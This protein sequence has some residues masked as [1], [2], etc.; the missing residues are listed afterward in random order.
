MIA[1]MYVRSA[2]LVVALAFVGS[3]QAGSPSPCKLATIADVKA[4]FGGTVGP[5]KVDN[6]AG[7]PACRFAVKKSNLGVDGTAVV[8][9]TPGQSAATFKIAKKEVPGAVAVAGVGNAAFYDPHT[10]SIEMLKG[11]AVADAQGIFLTASGP[12][13]TGAKI[14]ADVMI[15]AKAVA[16]HL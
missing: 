11:N 6:S 15:L 1:A 14:K 2:A 13:V 5:G 3:A 16:K 9:V 10:D 8:F 4:A 12:P 7:V